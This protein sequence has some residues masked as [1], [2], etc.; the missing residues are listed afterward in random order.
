MGTPAPLSREATHWSQGWVFSSNQPQ[1]WPHRC[2]KGRSRVQRSQILAG[3]SI[4]HTQQREDGDRERSTADISSKQPQPPVSLAQMLCREEMENTRRLCSQLRSCNM[5]LP[6]RAPDPGK[7]KRQE[8]SCVS[9]T[10]P[11]CQPAL[12]RPPLRHG[13]PLQSQ[14]DLRPGAPG[15]IPL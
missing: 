5:P 1:M 15:E 7:W 14:R 12:T 4:V 2:D 9:N 11:K 13:R 3:N 6:T 8:W 10:A